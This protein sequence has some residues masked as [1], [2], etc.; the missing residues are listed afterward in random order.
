MIALSLG[1]TAKQMRMKDTTARAKPIM[2]VFLL[3]SLTAIYPTGIN[4][5]ALTAILTPEMIDATPA[6]RFKAFVV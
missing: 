4:A 2:M 5:I 1:A 3:P 6:D